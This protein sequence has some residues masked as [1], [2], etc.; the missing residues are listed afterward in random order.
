MT[1][2][3]DEINGQET[4]KTKARLMEII[5]NNLRYERL[6]TKTKLL[7]L[8]EEQDNELAKHLINVIVDRG[9]LLQLLNKSLILL[10]LSW[11]EI[12]ELEREEDGEFLRPDS[13]LGNTLFWF[14]H[15]VDMLQ[16]ITNRPR[17][18]GFD[19]WPIN[20]V[21]EKFDEF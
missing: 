14:L 10:G 11:E 20:D 6:D 15:D 12:A 9:F 3:S 16:P 21:G 13:E 1:E 18:A 17:L 2:Q 4:P 8:A 19:A 7:E 5:K